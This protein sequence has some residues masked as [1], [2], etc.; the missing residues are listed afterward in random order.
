[1]LADLV[2]FRSFA[3][4]RMDGFEGEIFDGI[5][6]RGAKCDEMLSLIINRKIVQYDPLQIKKDLMIFD[7]LNRY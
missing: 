7:I 5:M 1:M 3:I 6:L 2:L 4:Q